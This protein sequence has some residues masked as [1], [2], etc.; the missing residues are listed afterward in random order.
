MAR[1]I[2]LL[3]ALTGC[4][5][6]SFDSA[7]PDGI[8]C[9]GG[10]RSMVDTETGD[11]YIAFDTAASFTSAEQTCAGLDAHLSSPHSDRENALVLGVQ[12]ARSWMGGTDVGHE[13]FST[14]TSDE[15][16][17]Y[18][19]WTTS[20]PNHGIEGCAQMIPTTAQWNEEDCAQAYPF[21][22]IRRPEREPV[23]LG[24]WGTPTVVVD[25]AIDEQDPTISPNGL[26]LVFS[27]QMPNGASSDLYVM[28]RTTRDDAWSAPVKMAINMAGTNQSEARFSSDGLRLYFGSNQGASYDVY[29][30][31]RDR[32]GMPWG[33]RHA[34]AE[35]NRDPDIDKF[36][37]VCSGGYY[38][39]VHAADG[40]ALEHLYAGRLG[41]GMPEVEETMLE[42]A[43]RTTSPQLMPD[44]KTAYITT[45]DTTTIDI[46]VSTRNAI[47]A[48]WSTPAT[49]EIDTPTLDESDPAVTTDQ[50]EMYFVHKGVNASTDL[51][52]SRR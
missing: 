5:R 35:V 48:P 19:N 13:D 6:I 37:S 31:E 15:A 28:T 47:G 44:C 17:D 10:D 23:T 46:K 27:L 41:S 25:S 22:C 8:A 1:A 43:G 21:S 34:L 4:G 3:F 9:S 38:L 2:I 20:E 52:V 7:P 49:L 24:A 18:A 14:W 50:R 45:S 16:W 26:E 33:S 39:M 11:C 30:V 42:N 32:L 40:A 51:F 12:P 29:Y 36:L